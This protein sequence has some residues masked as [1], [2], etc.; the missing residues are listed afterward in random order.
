[1]SAAPITEN[2]FPHEFKRNTRA[3]TICGITS[4]D[5][6]RTAL[7]IATTGASSS[8]H[9]GTRAFLKVSEGAVDLSRFTGAPLLKNHDWG[10]DSVIGSVSR[11]WISEGVLFAEV[12][13]ARHAKRIAN[14]VVDGHLLKVSIGFENLEVERYNGEY[15][16]ATRW[17]P[18]EISVV[19]LGD[20]P[21]ARFCSPAEHA[22]ALGDLADNQRAATVRARLKAFFDLKA[23]AWRSWV[24]T[25]AAALSALETSDDTALEN[26]LKAEVENHI[27]AL[28]DEIVNVTPFAAGGSDA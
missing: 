17:R 10:V 7:V 14:L 25:A 28:A 1:M 4:S 20:D 15:L 3:R 21:H 24:P 27:D 16:M 9:D 8:A 12:R 2:R 11:A 6:N 5:G 18:F 26:A 13:F 22:K 23:D 19:A